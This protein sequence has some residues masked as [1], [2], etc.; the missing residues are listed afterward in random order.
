VAPL[1]TYRTTLSHFGISHWL[2]RHDRDLSSVLD[3]NKEGLLSLLGYISLAYLG[4]ASACVLVS[5]P[6]HGAL[7]ATRLVAAKGRCDALAAG[8]GTSSL[9]A[10]V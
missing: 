6:Q 2:E 7:R 5:R 10:D 9:P 8:L 3:A 1:A 4:R